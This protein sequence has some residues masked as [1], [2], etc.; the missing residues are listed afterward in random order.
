MGRGL[1]FPFQVSDVGTPRTALRKDTV[2][3]QLEQLL[4][5]LPGE[6][7]NRPDFG[8]GVQRLVFSEASP[9]SA[10]TAEYVVSSAIAKHMGAV[11]DL[12][13]VR[14]SVD[15]TTLYI[16]VLYTLLDSGDELAATFSQPLQ[17]AP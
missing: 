5:T 16:D 15:D 11:I 8:C 12:D 9:E 3:Q 7:V 10:A 2:H 14:V 13:A 17:G 6:R 4:F 1:H